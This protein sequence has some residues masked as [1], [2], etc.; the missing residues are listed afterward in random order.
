MEYP[1]IAETMQ[2]IIDDCATDAKNLDGM[3]FTGKTVATA[4]G[5]HLAMTNAIARAVKDIAEHLET[6]EE[7]P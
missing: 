5:Q 3:P 1:D 6:Q 4:I 2:M 7:T